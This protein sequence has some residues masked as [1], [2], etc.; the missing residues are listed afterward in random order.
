MKT[1]KKL[2]FPEIQTPYTKKRNVIKKIGYKI[3][4]NMVL[5]LI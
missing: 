3:I 2:S 5:L 4:Q 1:V